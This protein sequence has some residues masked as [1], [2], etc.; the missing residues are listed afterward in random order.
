MNYKRYEDLSNCIRR[1]IWKIPQDVD[2]IVGIPRSGMIPSLMIAELLNKR[3]T[4]ID[5]FLDGRIL[6]CGGRGSLI[7]NN[8]ITKV[9]ILDDTVF[10]GGAMKRARQKVSSLADKYEILFGCIYAEG[11]N[12]KSLVDIYF[13]DNYVPGPHWLYEWNILHH[14]ESISK[15][16]I[17]DIDG[18]MC[19]EPP[20]DTDREAYEKYLPEA[21]PMIIPTTQIGAVV[22]YRLEQYRQV[23]EK[24][25]KDNGIDY[26]HLYMFNAP[27]RDTRGRMESP[28]KY[29]AR[30]YANAPWASLFFESSK[31]QAVKI[32]E[33]TGKSVFSYEDGKLYG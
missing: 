28:E 20:F 3:C 23:T 18:L 19:K 11:V 9:L 8:E 16:S 33:L 29:K 12:A 4:D 7:D 21:I 2:L 5:S 30:I 14:Y 15:N 25:L 24:W 10:G 17:W 31:S 13:E 1:N 6:S 26:R 22:T 32:H 27:D